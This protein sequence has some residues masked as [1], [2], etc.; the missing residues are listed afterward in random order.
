MPT[1]EVMT[2][3]SLPSGLDVAICWLPSASK[4]SYAM[5]RP[6]A[7]QSEKKPGCSVSTRAPEPFGR[8]VNIDPRPLSKVQVR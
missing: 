4:K 7:R 8:A 3:R 5:R 6:S 1:P 2:R